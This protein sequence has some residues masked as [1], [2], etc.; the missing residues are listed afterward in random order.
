[1]SNQQELHYNEQKQARRYPWRTLI[2]WVFTLLTLFCFE[3]VFPLIQVEVPRYPGSLVLIVG[4]CAVMLTVSLVFRKTKLLKKISHAGG[5][6]FSVSLFAVPVLFVAILPQKNIYIPSDVS[7]FSRVTHTWWFIVPVLLML[8]SLISAITH[9]M[10]QFNFRNALF[11]LNHAG[12]VLVLCFGIF[13]HADKLSVYISVPEGELVWYGQTDNGMEMELPLAIRLDKFTID[14][15]A[16]KI[17]VIKEGEPVYIDDAFF[18]SEK[19]GVA[20]YKNVSFRLLRYLEQA[21]PVDTGFIDARGIPYAT[22]AAKLEVETREIRTIAWVCAGN[23]AVPPKTIPAG[24]VYEVSMLPPEPKRYV[25]DISLFTPEGING[26]KHRISVNQPLSAGKW[27]IYQSSYNSEGMNARTV[28]VFLAVYDRWLFW[29]NAGFI[30]CLAGAIGL[31][32]TKPG[33][34]LNHE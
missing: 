23:E 20:R 1:M 11:F 18:S 32:F 27:R 12:L 8:L 16:P 3:S 10:K 13:G 5:A 30:L 22:A 25:S 26:E 24:G 2:L 21:F 6:L 14:Y 31:I 34:L 29:V 28:S 33:K 7:G 17:A 15:Y 9:R 4:I 19:M